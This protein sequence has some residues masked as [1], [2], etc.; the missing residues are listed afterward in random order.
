V[1]AIGALFFLSVCSSITVYD[2]TT[3]DKRLGCMFVYTD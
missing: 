1:V 2:C 3:E